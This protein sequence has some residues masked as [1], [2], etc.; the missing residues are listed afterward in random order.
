MS[1]DAV[2]ID[3]EEDESAAT[4]RLAAGTLARF[5]GGMTWAMI[6]AQLSFNRRRSWWRSAVADAEERGLLEWNRESRMWSLTD[7]GRE[8]VRSIS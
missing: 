2:D 8:H 5:V 3:D 6:H 1:R 4:A 7:A